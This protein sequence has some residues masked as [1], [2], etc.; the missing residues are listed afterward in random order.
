[1]NRSD[2]DALAIVESFRN[3]TS[4][5]IVLQAVRENLTP[6]Q[7]GAIAKEA[8][9][10]ANSIIKL[11]KHLREQEEDDAS[12]DNDQIYNQIV[13][14]NLDDPLAVTVAREQFEA[15]RGAGYFEKLSE[16]KA[17]WALLGD[18]DAKS[19]FPKQ[20]SATDVVEARLSE[21]ES[22]NNLTFEEL[23]ENKWKVTK[24][25]YT[26]MLQTL[27]LERG[28]AET[29]ALQ[30]F[31]TTFKYTEES[32]RA[33]MGTPS[34]Q[35]Y[36]ASAKALRR[37]IRE[38]PGASY[39]QIMEESARLIAGQ[40]TKFEVLFEA[41]KVG[42][43]DSAYTML[44]SSLQGKIPKPLTA[45]INDVQEAVSALLAAGNTDAMLLAFNTALNKAL[46]LRIF[47]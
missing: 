38:S 1:M 43:L 27:E 16:S 41:Y 4:G 17:V 22:F 15:L 23:H 12:N 8:T 46:D 34:R 3:G 39:R 33:L 45:N 44:P 24:Q 32:D 30:D 47:N 7:I 37:Y 14:V 11:R 36:N 42:A 18:T 5:D 2:A 10:Q 29:D 31:R 20:S 35:A 9:K 26:Q 28:E 6:E 40:K 21:T 19:A 25:F 13:N